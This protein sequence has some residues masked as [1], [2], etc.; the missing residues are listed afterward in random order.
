MPPRRFVT[1]TA[2]RFGD[3]FEPLQVARAVG[4]SA[5][6]QGY[7][8]PPGHRLNNGYTQPP[9]HRLGCYVHTRNCGH[10]AMSKTDRVRPGFALIS[11]RFPI[12][13]S[14]CVGQGEQSVHPMTCLW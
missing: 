8:Q 14:V 9:R 12:L 10:V 5:F 2:H 11:A 7:T 3:D 1:V 4:L 6:L 13:D